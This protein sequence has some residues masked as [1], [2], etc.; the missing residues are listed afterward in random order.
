ME[1]RQEQPTFAI[2]VNT[3]DKTVTIACDEC[4]GTIC[5]LKNRRIPSREEADAD[6]QLISTIIDAAIAWAVKHR[7]AVAVKDQVSGYTAVFHADCVPYSNGD[8]VH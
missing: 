5:V 4:G 8:P 7:N 1:T 6:S 2:A 3:A